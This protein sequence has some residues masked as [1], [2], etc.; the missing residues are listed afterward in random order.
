MLKSATGPTV[1]TTGG[2]VM[3]VGFGSP[4]GL[5]TLAVLVTIPPFAG[6]VTVSTRLVLA[7][8]AREP[9][10]QMTLP[11]LSDPPPLAL[12][13]VTLAGRASVTDTLAAVEG[14]RFVMIIV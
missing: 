1:V 8:A 2:A 14:P 11:P 10:V 6:A 3:L 4:V 9:S 5:P 7:L 12:T 13:N